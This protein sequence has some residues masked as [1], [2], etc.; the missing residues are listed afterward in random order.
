L[1]ARVEAAPDATALLAPERAPITFGELW[2]RIEA[3]A[4]GLTEAGVVRGDVVAVMLPDGPDLVATVL[5][6]ARAAACAPLNPA[7]TEVEIESAFA[8]LGARALIVEPGQNAPAVAAARALGIAVIESA[9][10]P[11]RHR[12]GPPAATM[13]C[14][15][16]PRPPAEIPSWFP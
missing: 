16:T 5:G 2:S 14:C 4:G 3:V 12:A 11:L 10:G 9:A 8:G 15:C 13:R 1:Q 6:V 7:L